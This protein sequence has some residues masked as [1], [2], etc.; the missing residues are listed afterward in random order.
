MRHADHRNSAWGF[1]ALAGM[2]LIGG[3]ASHR[4]PPTCKGAFTPINQ[5]MTA[6]SNDAQR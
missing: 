1:I 4:A 3:C 5:P 2:L 6:A